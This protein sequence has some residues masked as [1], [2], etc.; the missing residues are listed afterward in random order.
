MRRRAILLLNL[1]LILSLAF[2]GTLSGILVS[3]PVVTGTSGAPVVAPDDAGPDLAPRRVKRER[4][5]DRARS[6]C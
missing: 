5:H 6:F 4:R 1:S 3:A 2:S